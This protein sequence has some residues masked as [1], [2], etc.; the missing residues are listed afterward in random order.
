[1][2]MVADGGDVWLPGTGESAADGEYPAYPL[3]LRYGVFLVTTS[4]FSALSA[5]GWSESKDSFG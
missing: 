5:V 4:S 3:T 2:L 1:M